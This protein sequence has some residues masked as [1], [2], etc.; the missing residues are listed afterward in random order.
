MQ[1]NEPITTSLL[2]ANREAFEAAI[3]ELKDASYICVMYDCRKYDTWYKG[4]SKK[5]T[6]G[7]LKRLV[8]RKNEMPTVKQV[9]K[10]FALCQD[11]TQA[12]AIAYLNI[13]LTTREDLHNARIN[14]EG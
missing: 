12:M 4:C 9:E 5:K 10:V 1:T 11:L 2:E 3:N 6:N 13:E 14:W 7:I 8:N